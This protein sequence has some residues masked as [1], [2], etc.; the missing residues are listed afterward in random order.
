MAQEQRPKLQNDYE[1]KTKIFN[2]I[3]IYLNEKDKEIY[4]KT[5]KL[6]KQKKRSRK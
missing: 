5:E 3:D 4:S 6:Q 2:E 1:L